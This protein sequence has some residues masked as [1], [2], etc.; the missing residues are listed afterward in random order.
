MKARRIRDYQRQR[1]YDWESAIFSKLESTKLSLDRIRHIC[2]KVSRHYHI[3]TPI[4]GDG[5]AR[6]SAAWVSYINT[7]AFPRWSRKEWIVLHEM[8]HCVHW[9]FCRDFKSKVHSSHGPMFVAIYMFLLNRYFDVPITVLTSSAIDAGVD[10][11]NLD[12]CPSDALR[13]Y[14][15]RKK[16]HG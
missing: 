16:S 14:A 5:R 1:V 15:K 4:V 9:N 6:S 7:V 12:L 13:E 3:R 10:Y 2:N 11:G 8:S